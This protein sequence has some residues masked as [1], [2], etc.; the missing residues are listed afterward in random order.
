ML[1]SEQV[2]IVAGYA[3]LGELLRL[4][5]STTERQKRIRVIFGEEP[6][7]T[8]K[9]RFV[10]GRNSFSDEVRD[11]W[12]TQGISLRL[13]GAVIR[14]KQML[15][16]GRLQARLQ[17]GH[18]ELHAKIY[19]GDAAATVG[20]SNFTDAGLR[21]KREGN[22]RFIKHGEPKRYEETC[23]LAEVYWAGGLD[24]SVELHARRDR[25]PAPTTA[26]QVRLVM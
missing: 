16:E 1:S 8:T 18:V 2:L 22:A 15:S 23:S 9:T 5:A 19:V 25:A 17:H 7:Q 12:L 6:F 24:Y 21:R 20:S 11:H 3:S 10:L 13:S 14:A 4:V 26:A